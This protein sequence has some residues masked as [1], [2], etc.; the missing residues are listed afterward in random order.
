MLQLP[1]RFPCQ[2]RGLVLDS[3]CGHYR[4]IFMATSK[5]EISSTARQGIIRE[6]TV[7]T[8]TSVWNTFASVRLN[9]VSNFGEAGTK[10]LAN[11]NST[12]FDTSTKHRSSLVSEI[13]T[14]FRAKPGTLS[15]RISYARTVSKRERIL[16]NKLP[17]DLIYSIENSCILLFHVS[18]YV[19]STLVLLV[20]DDI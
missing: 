19:F 16:K 1:A 17:T 3:S 4:L 7:G 20:W 11:S 10:E 12:H 2:V 5:S 15:V 9:E 18:R 6:S 13:R 14:W 8:R